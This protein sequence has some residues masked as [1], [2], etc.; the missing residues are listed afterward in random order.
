V[1]QAMSYQLNL[2]G[3]VD[4]V[5]NTSNAVHYADGYVFA[6]GSVSG[7]PSYRR[8]IVFSFDGTTFTEIDR[9]DISTANMGTP[10]SL[11]FDGQYVYVGG[12]GG[13]IAIYT[14]NG[15][16]LTQVF[17]VDLGS[18]SVNCIVAASDGYIYVAYGDELRAYTFDGV[19][20]TLRGSVNPVGGEIRKL[21]WDGTRIH[22]TLTATAAQ[23]S[24]CIY[25]FDGAN[26]TLRG[27]SGIVGVSSLAGICTDGTYFYYASPNT[28]LRIATWAG[29]GNNYNNLDSLVLPQGAINIVSDGKYIY[30]GRAN[31]CVAIYQYVGGVLQFHSQYLDAGVAGNLLNNVDIGGGYIYYTSGNG[32]RAL[33]IDLVATFNVNVLNGF[34][35]TPR[36]FTAT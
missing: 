25:S 17:W 24:V 9:D 15:T 27:N 20:L 30:V 14:F 36:I 11:S 5:N 23:D 2:K 32:I 1:G 28:T 35:G 12:D 16:T 26:F 34:V 31:T 19:N 10:R 29:D 4:F 22:L 6:T 3:S 7:P 21:M 8:V 13:Q 33:R 18:S